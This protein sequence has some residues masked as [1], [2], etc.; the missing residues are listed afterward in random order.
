MKAADV[1]IICG[2]M[3][4]NPKDKIGAIKPGLYADLVAVDADPLAN[5]AALEHVSFVMK[6]GAV[7]VAHGVRP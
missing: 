7:V 2:M 5:V 6:G 1:D 4:E 3:T